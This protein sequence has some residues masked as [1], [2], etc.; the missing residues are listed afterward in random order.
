MSWI[1]SEIEEHRYIRLTHTISLCGKI[2]KVVAGQGSDAIVLQ[3]H[4]DV[5]SQSSEFFKRIIKPE[6]SAMREDPDTIEM[7]TYP[8]IDVKTYAQWLYAGTIPTREADE[9]NGTKSD[10]IWIDLVSNSTTITQSISTKLCHPINRP[11]HT[12]SAKR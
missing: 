3:I 10:P 5:L 9:I 2:L 8:V 11:T 4:Q 7:K 1:S 6:W 12:S